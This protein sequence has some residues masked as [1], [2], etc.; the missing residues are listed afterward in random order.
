MESLPLNVAFNEA[1]V[2]IKVVV[3]FQEV[4]VEAGKVIQYPLTITNP[5]DVDRPLLLSVEPPADWKVVFKSGA[6]EVTNLYLLAGSSENLVVEATPP[7]A[8]NFS[9]YQIPVQIKSESGDIYAE[10]NLK[11]TIV[12]SYAL[13]LE[14]STLL[15]SVTTGSSVTFTAKITNTGYTPVTGLKVGVNVPS[16]WDSSITP[17]QVEALNPSASYTFTLVATAPGDTVAGDYMVTLTALS[18][19]V[20]SDA[21]QVRVTASTPTSWGLIGV[22]VAVV[23]VVAL[24]IVFIKFRRR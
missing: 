21:V 7:S 4:T 18:D 6:L 13:S 5:S 11:A 14:P 20:N 22:G 8:A 2:N 24:L 12:G 3:K 15:T 9:A 10:M 23:M 17:V 19:Q 1:E 16:G